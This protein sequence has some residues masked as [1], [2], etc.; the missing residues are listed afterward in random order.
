MERSCH[1]LTTLEGEVPSKTAPLLSRLC[2]ALVA[3]QLF[4]Q[5][6]AGRISG[7]VIDTSGAVIA[8]ASVIITNQGTALKWKA[9]T[10]SSGFYVGA[11]LPVGGYKVEIEGAGFRKAQ[12]TG[13][14]LADA[15]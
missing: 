6:N 15:A 8:G 5:T 3:L 7:T 1:F 11:N 10:N 14:D 4:A 13:L 9:V 2:I 12:K